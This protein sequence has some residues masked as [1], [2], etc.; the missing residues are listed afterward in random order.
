MNWIRKLDLKVAAYVN[1]AVIIV[2]IIVHFLV[3]IQVMPFTWINGGRSVNLAAAQQTSIT[4]IAVLTVMILIN[5]WAC[6]LL[7]IK[8]LMI[9]L[10]V[11]LW[12]LFAY[13]IFGMI[14][15]LF[16]TAFERF[17]MSILC[18]TNMIMYFRLAIEKR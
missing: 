16:G 4:S 12:I 11:L 14:Q 1:I 2:A 18:I 9:L 13:S 8:K 7:P 5:L 15:Q 10:K 3:M 17:S 6:A